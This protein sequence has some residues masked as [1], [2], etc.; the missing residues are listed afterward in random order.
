MLVRYGRPAWTDRNPM[1]IQRIDTSRGTWLLWGY[2]HLGMRVWMQASNPLGTYD[3]PQV[4]PYRPPAAYP[5]SIASHPGLVGI[6]AGT[7]VFSKL[8]PRTEA[9]PMR[10]VLARFEGS[11]SRRLLGHAEIPGAP[12]DSFWMEWVVQDTAGREVRRDV[13]SMSISACAP[14]EARAASFTTDLPPSRYRVGLSARGN[15]R[16]AVYRGIVDLSRPGGDLALSDVVVTC[17]PPQPSFEAGHG[18]RLEPNPGARLTHSDQLTAYF[19]I[20]HLTPES[21]GLSRFEY[22]YTVRS[23]WKDPRTWIQRVLTPRRLQPPIAASRSEESVGT[24]R[25]QY[26][27]VPIRELPDGPYELEIRVRDLVSGAET[28]GV[29]A[30]TRGD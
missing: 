2:P 18:V 25:R 16:R 10:S 21:G 17:G 6:G 19:E 27:T 30:F 24:I 3:H 22:V 9:L 11:G 15:G 13:R 8:P 14:T 20:Y 7:A 29:A 1:F 12:T 4:Y 26:L 28:T 23:A 5:D